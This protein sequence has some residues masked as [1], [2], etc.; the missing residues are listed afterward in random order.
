MVKTSKYHKCPT[1]GKESRLRQN[2]VIKKLSYPKGNMAV[3]RREDI[4]NVSDAWDYASEV[5]LH[6]SKM[7]L[8]YPPLEPLESKIADTIYDHFR[9]VAPHTDE[10]IAEFEIIHREATEAKVATQE[11]KKENGEKGKHQKAKKWTQEKRNSERTRQLPDYDVLPATIK[12]EP[13]HTPVPTDSGRITRM[14]LAFL[15]GSIVC[16]V[17]SN[18]F[19]E[20]PLSD[21]AKIFAQAIYTNYS[22]FYSDKRMRK[23]W[24]GWIK[25]MTDAEEGG[26]GWAA[27]NHRVKVSDS[28][29]NVVESKITTKHMKRMKLKVFRK[30]LDVIN[31]VEMFDELFLKYGQF[32]RSDVTQAAGFLKYFDKLQFKPYQRYIIYEYYTYIHN[33]NYTKPRKHT[34]SRQVISSE[35]IEQ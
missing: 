16:C 32:V 10:E 12:V 31:Y 23:D 21:S 18:T 29:G 26:Y 9:T 15:Y 22:L 7:A 35:Q 4:E 30:S 3:R 34:I 25:L 19:R 24:F 28:K 33:D 20:L 17:I 6:M 5:C 2:W 13:R 8:E 14:S 1:C 27:W 11:K